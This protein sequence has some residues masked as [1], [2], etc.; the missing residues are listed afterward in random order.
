MATLEGKTMKINEI[1]EERMYHRGINQTMICKECGMVVQ[2]F[3]AFLKGNRNLTKE[4]LVKVMD[5][6]SLAYNKDGS[7]LP[8]NLIEDKVMDCLKACNEKMVTVAKGTNISGSTLSSIISGKRK[9]SAKVLNA[10]IDYFGFEVR[11]IK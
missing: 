1:I 9:M 4:S 6:L 7:M 8:P 3:N 2:N 5:F 11:T 10:L